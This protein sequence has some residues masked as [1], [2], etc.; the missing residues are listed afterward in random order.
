MSPSIIDVMLANSS[1]LDKI[2][3]LDLAGQDSRTPMLAE[4]LLGG[5]LDRNRQGPFDGCLRLGRPGCVE[6]SQD[7]LS[8]SALVS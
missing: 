3:A 8:G 6:F 2:E 1:R 5:V 4:V 7:Y